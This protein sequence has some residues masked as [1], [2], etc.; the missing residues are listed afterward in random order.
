LNKPVA[1]EA[2][3]KQGSDPL[4]DETGSSGH[5]ADDRV[6]VSTTYAPSTGSRLRLFAGTFAVILAVAFFVV[7]RSRGHQEATLERSTTEIAGQPPPVEVITVNLAPATQALTLPGET[8]GWYNSTIYARVSGYVANWVVDIGDKVKKDQVLA[9]IDTPE[10]DAQ[11]EA[12]QAQ[13]KASQAEVTVRETDVDF[14]KTT[15]ER[16]QGSP[17][18]VVSD[19]EREDKKAR[20]AAAEAQLNAARAR[21][22]LDQANVDRLT[23]LTSFKQVT[24][25]YDGVITERHLD[26]GDLVTAGSTSNTSSLYGIAQSDTIRVFVNVPQS[27]STDI[28]TGTTAQVRVSEH[29]D[30]VFEGKVARTSRAIDRRART[31][32]V[33]VDLPNKDFAL[34]PGMYVEVAF[35]LKP[36]NF[37]QVPAS[38]LLFRT[39]G[40][41]VALIQGTETVKFQDVTIARDNGNFV[42]L[43]SGV[44]AGDKV[45]LNIS[46][47]IADGDKVTARENAKTA[48][49]K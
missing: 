34:L 10:L 7:H 42:E 2:L 1:P 45:A 28:R 5:Q 32:R 21:V 11:L 9:T 41:Q 38:A 4:E 39:S 6:P 3:P 15:Y 33:E 26:V 40:P 23:F 19:Q 49:A 44:S 46:S 12:A 16:W 36:T 30:K 25:P 17:K 29:A 27:A 24:A 31:L 35:H 43:A 22:A 47:Q 8:R 20:Y 48:E 13:I 37:V 18:G 14:A